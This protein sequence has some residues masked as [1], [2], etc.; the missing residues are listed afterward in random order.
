MKELVRARQRR[1]ERRNGCAQKDRSARSMKVSPALF[2]PR[3]E[4]V[5][6]RG[7]GLPLFFSGKHC[8]WSIL[9]V[10]SFDSYIFSLV[11]QRVDG[12]SSLYGLF[13]IW[14]FWFWGLLFGVA[15]VALLFLRSF[16]MFSLV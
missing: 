16:G 14:C 1:D 13:I 4:E 12:V 3:R 15:E 7:E 10:Y 6:K 9:K 5:Y 11:V 2:S 8:A